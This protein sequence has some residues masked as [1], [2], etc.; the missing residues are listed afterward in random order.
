MSAL[1]VI[2]ELRLADRIISV[3]LA[4]MTTDQQEKCAAMLER[5]GISNDGELRRYE[6]RAALAAVGAA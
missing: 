6:R 4:S 5:D 1:D 2:A 3:M